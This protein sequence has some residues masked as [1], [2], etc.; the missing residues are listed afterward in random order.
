MNLP[1]GRQ[2]ASSVA[3]LPPGLRRCLCAPTYQLPVSPFL[4]HLDQLPK[5]LHRHSLSVELGVTLVQAATSSC[6]SD[7]CGQSR[8]ADGAMGQSPLGSHCSHPRGQG[9]PPRL[10]PSEGIHT[11]PQATRGLWHFPELQRAREAVLLA[12]GRYPRET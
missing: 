7:L 11:R 8:Q 2:K 4:G 5:F 3:N 9:A 6:H 12:L 10:S 1:L